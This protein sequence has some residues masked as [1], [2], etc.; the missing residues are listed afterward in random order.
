MHSTTLDSNTID[1]NNDTTNITPER[2]MS[3]QP[4][5]NKAAMNEPYMLVDEIRNLHPH[6]NPKVPNPAP[7]GLFAFGLTTAL[8]QTKHTGLAGNQ[9]EDDEGTEALVLGFAMFFGGLLQVIAGLSEVRRNNIFGYTAF[10]LYGGLWMSLGTV[11]IIQLLATDMESISPNPK[12][13]E[14]MFALAAIFTTIL[15]FGT[16]RLNRTIS[17]LFFLLAVTLYLLA[18]GVRDETVDKVG[19]W[20][21]L[22]TSAVAYWLAGAEL[23]NDLYGL[24]ED[25]NEF[26]PL[27]HFEK[28]VRKG[29]QQRSTAADGVDNED[30]SN[31]NTAGDLEAGAPHEHGE[32]L[33]KRLVVAEQAPHTHV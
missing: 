10:L 28:R 25:G 13:T 27:G 12:A 7:L 22:A 30:G 23:L 21:G 8:L 15:W 9:E 14:A 24:D 16:F 19:G 5:R 6:I 4:L 11:D 32:A 26:I 3:T 1:S 31:E 29:R 17:L 2:T 20:F 33:T 18:G